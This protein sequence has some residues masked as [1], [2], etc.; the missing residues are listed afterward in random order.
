MHM[1]R[2]K[3][4]WAAAAAVV[5]TAVAAPTASRLLHAQELKCYFKDCVVFDDGSRLC[6]VKEVPCPQPM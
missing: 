4:R 2:R 6:E 1:I 3:V 5:V